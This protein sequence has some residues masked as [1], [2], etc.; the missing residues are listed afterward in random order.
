M[1]LV[2]RTNKNIDELQKF[3]EEGEFNKIENLDLTLTDYSQ[4]DYPV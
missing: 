2:I 1:A 3:I 4:L